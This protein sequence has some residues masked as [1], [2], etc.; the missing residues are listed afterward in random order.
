MDLLYSMRATSAH[1]EVFRAY[2]FCDHGEQAHEGVC[3][4]TDDAKRVLYW[5]PITEFWEGFSFDKTSLRSAADSVILSLQFRGPG[6]ER[7]YKYRV[8]TAGI[9]ELETEVL[10]EEPRPE[11]DHA[12]V[13]HIW[14]ARDG[15]SKGIRQ[16]VP[17]TF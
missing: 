17:R 9:L 8:R 15:P 2:V 14:P 3:V 16:T 12:E 6:G 5:W 1:C 7:V 11:A 4:V 13:T 10:P